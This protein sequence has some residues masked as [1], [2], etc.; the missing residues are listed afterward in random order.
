MILL[1]P[2]C[3]EVLCWCCPGFVLW[4]FGVLF[5]LAV[6]FLRKRESWLLRF[7]CDVAVCSMSLPHAS[8]SWSSVCD[9][10]ISLTYIFSYTY[11]KTYLKRPL[12]MY[13]KIV[14]KYLLSLDA[15][16]KYFRMLQGEHSEI[17]STFIKLT[18]FIETAVLSIF[19]WLL[20]T[21]FTVLALTQGFSTYRISEKASF[22]R[23]FECIQRGLRSYVCVSILCIRKTRP[24]G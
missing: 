12:K 3:V 22:I 8:L 23:S 7:N 6:I 5:S 19:K 10:C 4:F 14:F 15:G 20:K 11:S 2:L 13:T 9:C 16:Q 1:R 24:Q 18:F 21:G 17:L